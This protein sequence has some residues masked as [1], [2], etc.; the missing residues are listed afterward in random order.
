MFQ[1]ECVQPH[2]QGDSDA[3]ADIEDTD[4]RCE[5]DQRYLMTNT[6]IFYEVAN[7]GRIRTTSLVRFVYPPVTG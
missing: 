7:C 1:E 5:I 3:D 2:L 6:Y 4:S